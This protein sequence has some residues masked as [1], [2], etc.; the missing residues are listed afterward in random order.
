ML[1]ILL[2]PSSCQPAL[3]EASRQETLVRA[4]GDV[5]NRR[6][7]LWHLGKWHIGPTCS[8]SAAFRHAWTRGMVPSTPAGPAA[9]CCSVSGCSLSGEGLDGPMVEEGSSVRYQR[10]IPRTP[11]LSEEDGRGSRPFPPHCIPPRHTTSLSDRSKRGMIGGSQSCRF[12]PPLVLGAAEEQRVSSESRQGNRG[13]R[14]GGFR[15]HLFCKRI[16]N[17]E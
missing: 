3:A 17:P 8:A 11:V 4:T 12:P 16:L 15:R 5:G 1:F 10:S 14:K 13:L 6:I 9:R 7:S 2:T